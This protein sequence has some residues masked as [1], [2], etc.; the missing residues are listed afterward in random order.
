MS[1]R[2]IPKSCQL[3]PLPFDTPHFSNMQKLTL[4]AAATGSRVDREAGI[5]RG[6]SVITAG[7]EAKGHG[8]W[9]DQTSLE[10][11]KA[12]AETYI[13]GLQVK[14]DHGSGFGEIEGVLRDFVIEGNQL[15]ADF[16]LIKSGEEYERIMEMAE[17]MPSSFGLS[18]EFSGISEEIDEYRYARPVEIYAVALVDQPAAN[19]SGLFQAMPEDIKP[20]E[21]P[22]VASVEEVK[23]EEVTESQPE[24]E[25]ADEAVVEL[26]VDGPKGTQ[27]D[28][29]GPKEVKGPEGTQN[30]PADAVE[31]AAEVVAP[32][33]AAEVEELPEEKLSS[34]LSEV[35]LNFENTK[36]EVINLRA[37]LE[38]AHRNLSALKAEVEKRD[39]TIAKL[40]DLKRIALRAAGL[41]PSDVEIEIEAQAA[42]FN[43]AEAYAAAVEAGDKKLAAELFKQHKAAIFAARRN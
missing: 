7:V 43:P 8:I 25:K 3:P 38:T 35:V 36:A 39:L 19:P 11:V 18:I 10:M 4:F 13:D 32:E 21:V 37:D 22:P 15:R 30:L 24:E 9:I 20:E 17:M 41:L 14:S 42:P 5:L 1:S 23:V 27:H 6:V 26:Q 12:S 29:E 34:K 2:Q 16:H 31:P 33:P 28:P 40:E